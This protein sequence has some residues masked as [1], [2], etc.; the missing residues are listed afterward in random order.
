MSE[1]NPF[2]SVSLLPYQ[3]PPF[4]L[5]QDCHYRPAFDEGV[6]QQR[7]EIR[8]IIDNPEPAN[9]ANTLEALE[10]S[11]QLLAR[12]TRVFFAMAG[13]HT[14]PFI[15]S[16]DEEFSAELAELGNDIWLNEALFQRVN[17]V[18][19][20][21][22]AL[23]LDSESHR[24]LTLTW[25]RFVHAGATL[26]PA[27]KAVL[28]TLNTE[29]A[30]LQSQFQQRL[31]G[32]AKSGGLVVDYR[33]QLDGLADEEIAAAADAA[34]EKG[35]SD[36]WLLTLTNTT[37]QPPLLSLR[38][39]QTRENL[40]AAGWTRN[41]QGDEHD[42]RRL[43]LRLAAIRAQQAELLGAAD[44]ASWALTDQMAA[45]P[46]EALTFMRRIAPAARARAE[47]E[48]ADIQQVI[49]NEGGA[50][51]AAAWDWLYYSE[52]VRR[53]AFAIDDSQLKPYFALERVL[54]DGV[55]WTATQLFGLRFVERFDIPVYHPDVRV[56][57]IFDHNGEG[58]A[59]FYGD[60]YAR[61][62]K[63]GGAWMDVFVE[64]STLREQRPVIYNVCN[65][66]RPQAGQSALLSW[67][68][69]ITLFHEFGHT[70]HGLFASQPQVFAHYAKHYQS[71]EPM[72]EA[73]RDN[74]L[75]AATFN[76]GY[77][78]SELL[79][80][81][82]LDMRWHSLSTSA[83]PEDVDGFEQKILQE[84]HL[85]LAA[86]P[87]RYRSSYFSHIF[88]GGYAAGYYAYLW[89]Q[90]LADDGYQWFVEQGGLTR[91]NG[92]RFREAILSRGNS[93]DL[94]E[95][96]RQWRGHDPQIEPMLENRGLNA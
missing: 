74:M 7:A 33:H 9:F 16:L 20:Q 86:V 67:D 13:A 92:Q 2:F 78:M 1:Q 75:R 69:V 39:R 65:Y 95:L 89:T 44:Y 42:T 24:L 37:Q 40:F 80:A 14:N 48:L 84:E 59:L 64:Q 38:D 77:D 93:T 28:R 82:L 62:S 27:Q 47:R 53:A 58:M 76:K 61:D 46:A 63:S 83:I 36:C 8:A 32:A 87:P 22:D 34:R 90:M 31:L 19:E 6:R 72:P 81:A 25:Q 12:V 18:Y 21:R 30:T 52:Q 57:E 85:D 55:F 29:A 4:D 96:Y 70:L 5:I 91:E 79:A 54:Q 3:A 10:Q 15:Q 17:S 66:A 35:L 94:A 68:E 26:A 60:Y 73:L 56:W 45:S 51:R 23:A 71:G 50:F 41:Q 43:V 49:D 11:G 88:G